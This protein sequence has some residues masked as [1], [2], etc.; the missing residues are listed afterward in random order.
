MLHAFYCWPVCLPMLSPTWNRVTEL[1]L[2]GP[3]CL[4][5]GH[6]TASQPTEHAPTLPF[7]PLVRVSTSASL[8]SLAIFASRSGDLF[9]HSLAFSLPRHPFFPA[10]CAPRGGCHFGGGGLVHSEISSQFSCS[11]T[12][13]LLFFSLC[14][15]IREL[16][17]TLP[18]GLSPVF[19][20]YVHTEQAPSNTLEPTS[21]IYYACKSMATDM[22]NLNQA[23][24]SPLRDHF[25]CTTKGPPHGSSPCHSLFQA[26]RLGQTTALVVSATPCIGV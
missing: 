5:H 12:E 14:F 16:F 19:L 15:L 13:S 11:Q 23:T 20:L 1:R 4:G 18:S 26:T 7:F 8:L 25:P 24:Q 9:R 2:V 22:N 3:L 21:F 10:D 6:L 17:R